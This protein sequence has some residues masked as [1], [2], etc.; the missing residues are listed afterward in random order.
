MRWWR[1][2]TAALGARTPVGRDIAA[3][4]ALSVLGL[5]RPALTLILTRGAAVPVTALVVANLAATGEYAV[6]AIR[7]LAPRSA[8]GLATA[9]VLA[10]AA[11][12]SN[13]GTGLGVVVCA[14]TVASVLP[15]GEA[16][17]AITGW[18]LVHG[19]GGAVASAAGADFEGSASLLSR[20]SPGAIDLV[21][22]TAI[23][24]GV[25]GLL[26]AYR[27]T[28][29]AYTAELVARAERSERDR[30][31]QARHAVAEERGRIA[32]ELHDIAAHDLSAI[33]VQAGAADRQVDR[34][35]LAAK[36]TLRSIR[37]QGR[38][39][40][41][42]LR[43]LVG[44]MRESDG[45][46]DG[47]APQ[48]GLAR[49]D[50]LVAGARAADM[51]VEL[52]E[53]GSPLPLRPM[54]DLTLYRVVQEA[55]TNARRHAPGAAVGIAVAHRDTGVLVTVRNTAPPRRPPSGAGG[56][57]GLL[58]MRERVQQAGGW[59]VFGPTPDGGWRLRAD[60]PR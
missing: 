25:P 23:S 51:M 32:R 57:H 40:L 19:L 59:L 33:V 15:R 35:P 4:V 48:P 31:E 58:G 52:E 3:A 30:E 54:V 17:R 49:L 6:I 11:V 37:A 13:Y 27:H 43:R 36:A 2:A 55:L 7:R 5:I 44:V 10:G 28:R 60:L 50:E 8:L 41:R 39:T 21:V 18:A 9:V 1:R 14:Y 24:Y 29:R 47:R 34:D 38:A 45:D 12:P 42:S 20:A 16:L 56:G 26:G 46:T 22:A 53:T